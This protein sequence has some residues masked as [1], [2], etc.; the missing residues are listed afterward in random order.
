MKTYKSLYGSYI[1]PDNIREAII[2]A[3][4]G[5]RNRQIMRD[6]Y[7]EPEKWIPIIQRW[8]ENFKNPPHHPVQIYDGI[9]RKQRIIICPT[10]KEQVIHHM[11]CNI[12]KPIFMRGMYEHS[13]GSVPER[14]GLAGKKVIEKWIKNDRKN[15]KY[16]LKMDIRHFFDSV[17][18]DILKRKLNGIIK[19][20]KFLAILFEVINE[21][22]IGLP[23]GFYTSQWL[24]NWYLQD[25][26]HYIKEQLG[27]V[28]YIRYM[29]DMVVFGSN[30]RKLHKMRNDIA[31]YMNDEL[32]LEMKSNW[33]VY[34]FDHFD[35]KKGKRVGRDLDFMGFRF[36][37]DR[38]VMRKS[39]MFKCTRKARRMAKKEHIN[40]YDARQML[41]Y[42][43][44]LDHTDTYNVYLEYVK[45]A[46]NIKKLKR[47][48]SADDKRKEKERKLIN[49]LEESG[50]RN[51]TC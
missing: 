8:N 24:A 4:K 42:L 51:Q 38:T 15:C 7:L 23:L 13:Y 50:K 44:W 49:E 16:V 31:R 6:M 33:Q 46:V 27:A 22:E 3:S 43:G 32:G 2:N 19:D 30:K 21:T 28:H 11:L 29:D 39:I 9:S 41:S 48:V 5:K 34:R 47:R 37:C 25:L 1:S 36:F 35:A 14:G 10:N 45:P 12:L 26:D 18:H 17:P 40:V 20:E